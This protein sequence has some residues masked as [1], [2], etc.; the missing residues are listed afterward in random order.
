[1][2]VCFAI[3][4]TARHGHRLFTMSNIKKSRNKQTKKNFMF[5]ILRITK[6][7]DSTI[8][9]ILSSDCKN[10]YIDLAY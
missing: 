10:E 5:V 9:Y 2:V 1:M 4:P 3:F 8:G 7:F 6:N